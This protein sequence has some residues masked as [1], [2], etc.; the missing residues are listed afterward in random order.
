MHRD[1]PD[2]IRL[3][4]INDRVRETGKLICRARIELP[5]SRVNL[6][7]VKSA[8]KYALALVTAPNLITA[9][10]LAREA[11]R[12]RLIACANLIPRIESHYHWRGKI[13]KGSEVLLLLKTTRR[14]LA[15]LEKFIVA[16][17][18]YDTP[19]FLVMDLAAGN[20]RYLQWLFDSV[21]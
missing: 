5:R 1:Y 16:N 15:A 10:R 6:S 7:G 9:R 21:E 13:E 20:A 19:E 3:S 14:R 12:A 4:Q 8:R 17:H 18:S 2:I 11:L